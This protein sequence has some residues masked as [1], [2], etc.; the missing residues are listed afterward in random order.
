MCYECVDPVTKGFR[1]VGQIDIT[2]IGKMDKFRKDKMYSLLKEVEDKN[3][4]LTLENT[5]QLRN[6]V[7]DVCRE[8]WTQFSGHKMIQCGIAF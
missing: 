1:H 5:K 3:T 7:E 2:L 6:R 8:R 4:K